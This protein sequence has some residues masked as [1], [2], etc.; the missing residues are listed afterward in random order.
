LNLKRYEE[1][2]AKFREI[3][4]TE[5]MISKF[6][7]YYN[8]GLIYLEENNYDDAENALR[9]AVE[10]NPNDYRVYLKLGK[11]AMHKGDTLSAYGDYQ[12]AADL[13]EGYYSA[14]Q[15]DGPEIY[16][17]L[18]ENLIKLNRIEEGRNAFLKVIKISPEGQYGLKA[19]QILSKLPVE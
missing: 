5:A 11:I 8:I 19:K 4:N 14:M 13:I 3:I 2:K 7:A 15:S 1:A 9:K 18:G 16:Y 12:K 10:E 17:Y 6:N